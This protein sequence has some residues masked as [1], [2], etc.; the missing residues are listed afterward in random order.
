[1]RIDLNLNI[2]SLSAFGDIRDDSQ[3]G[4]GNNKE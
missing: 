4:D 1:M 2:R 3:T